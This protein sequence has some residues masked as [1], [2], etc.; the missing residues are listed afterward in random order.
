VLRRAASLVAGKPLRLV[1]A[2]ARRR[3]LLFDVPVVGPRT[4]EVMRET[5]ATALAIDA[6]RTLLIDREELIARADQEQI[7]IAS[8]E[9]LA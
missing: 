6:A 1:K 2:S 7:A 9:P 4:I 5:N 3:H 8:A